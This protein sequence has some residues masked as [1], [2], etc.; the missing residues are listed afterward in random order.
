[1]RPIDPL[2]LGLTLIAILI[3]TTCHEFA[4]AYV[5]DRLGDPTAR[6]LGRLSLNPLVHLDLLGTLFFV[7]FGFGWAR[8]VPVN[9]SNFQS[10]RQGMLQVAAAGPLANVTVAFIFGALLKSPPDTFP[11]L[12]GLVISRVVWINVILAVFNLIPVPPL[13]GS[14]ILESVLPAEQA[15]AFSRLR[16]YGMLVLL[17]L[18]YT[19]VVREVLIPAAQWLYAMSTGGGS[20]F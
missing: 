17:L 5:A 2:S 6:S 20:I 3:A 11:P 1:V 9:S 19:G 13:D 14:Q 7:L 4:H 16:P 8:P 12:V 15:L 10:P 18:L